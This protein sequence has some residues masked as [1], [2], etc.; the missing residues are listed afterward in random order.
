MFMQY[1]MFQYFMCGITPKEDVN[2]TQGH[3]LIFNCTHLCVKSSNTTLFSII[4]VQFHA[5]FTLPC[6]A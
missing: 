4:K 6:L 2:V 3:K 1:I 5:I